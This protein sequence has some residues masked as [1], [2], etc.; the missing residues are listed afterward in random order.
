[1]AEELSGGLWVPAPHL[2]L[3]SAVLA[4]VARLPGQR[5]MVTMPPQHGK[6]ELSSRWGVTWALARDPARRVLIAS[7]GAAYATRHGRWVRNAMRAYGAELGVTLADDATRMDE[8]ETTLGGGVTSSGVGEGITGRGFDLIVIDDPVKGRA[9]VE[10]PAYRAK[11][12]GWYTD[13]LATRLR[14]G[15]SIVVVMT[16]WHRDDL[17]GRL[18]AEAAAGGEEWEQVHLPAIA[19]EPEAVVPCEVCDGDGARYRAGQIESCATCGG[20]GQVAREPQPDPIGRMPGEALWP[21]RYPIPALEANRRRMGPYGFSALYQGRPIPK[22]GGAYWT[23]DDLRAAR[24][25]APRTAAGE[26]S[27]ELA[28]VVVA[29]D[30]AGSANPGSDETGIVVAGRERRSQRAGV[31]SDRSGVMSTDEWGQAAVQAYLDHQADA[32]VYERN[33]GG[34]AMAAVMRTAA[35]ALGVRVPPLIGVTARRSKAL[36]A[37]PVHQLYREGQV[38]HASVWPDLEEQAVTW[39]PDSKDSPDRLDALVYAITELLLLPSR[40]LHRR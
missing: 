5:V 6:T 27:V 3:L 35:K 19:E 8:W 40:T 37:E 39:R 36:R 23:D 25:R 10:S 11:Q 9:D 22:G 12:W 2:L 20:T 21:D 7:Y 13:D 29:V 15:A 26:L 1:M 30:P 28:R 24:Q 33:Y 18:L 16:R 31:L 38:W 14:P 32:I 4:K 34:D 17:A